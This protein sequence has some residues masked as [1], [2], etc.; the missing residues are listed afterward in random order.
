MM[1]KRLQKEARERGESSGSQ[2]L[3]RTAPHSSSKQQKRNSGMGVPLVKSPSDTTIYA[4][5]LNMT[6][7]NYQTISTGTDYLITDQDKVIH[8]QDKSTKSDKNN[9]SQLNETTSQS[10]GMPNGTNGMKKPDLMLKISNFVD[11]LRLDFEDSYVQQEQDQ[12]LIRPRSSINAPGLQEAQKRMEQAL[13]ETEKFKAT[14]E[15][16]PGRNELSELSSPLDVNE[17]SYPHELLNNEISQTV[18]RQIIRMGNSSGTTDDDFFH[19]TCHIEPNMKSK[20]ENGEFID[21]DKLLPKENT[22]QGRIITNNET[23]LE[24]VQ[25]EGSTYLVPA[26]TTSQINCFRRWEQAFHM[27]ATIYCTKN[28]NRAQ[29]IWQYISVINTASMSYNWDNVYNYDIVFRQLMEFNPNRSRAVTYNQMWNLSMTNPILQNQARRSFG[30]YNNSNSNQ[31]N[32][33][34][35]GIAT[36][37]KVDYCWRFNKGAKCKFGKKCKFIER[38][39]YCDDPSHGVVHCNKLEK[40]EK[41]GSFKGGKK[42]RKTVT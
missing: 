9:V 21:L 14:L 26:K 2:V 39:S 36:K 20:I 32:Q 35:S 24:W 8:S 29:E 10:G 19:L 22:Y 6:G 27:Y 17:I 1:D 3:T 33:N 38:C 23:K 28:P 42:G 31:N 13:I 11:Q 16:P 18:P 12:G 5:A 15:K 30:S 4:P 25:R 7:L 34:N 41:E 40:K 37:R